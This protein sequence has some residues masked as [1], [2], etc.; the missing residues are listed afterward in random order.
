[1]HSRFESLHAIE[2]N[3]LAIDSVANGEPACDGNDGSGPEG[4]RGWS[5]ED[6][7]RFGVGL[8]LA[9]YRGGALSGAPR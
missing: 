8:D 6:T 4:R 1:M 5:L 2:A 7:V 3:A 9:H